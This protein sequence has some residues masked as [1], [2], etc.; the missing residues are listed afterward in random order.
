MAKKRTH[1]RPERRSIGGPDRNRRQRRD[2]SLHPYIL[3][4][5]LCLVIAVLAVFV[6]RGYII[7]GKVDIRPDFIG[8]A[9]PFDRFAQDFEKAYDETPLWYPHIFGGMPFQASGTYHHLQ[10]SFEA[11]INAVL[12][13]RLIGALHGR[14]FFHLLLGAVSMF[15]LSRALSLS[16]PASFIAATAFVFS[17]HM[18]ATEHAN[19]FICFMHVPLVFLAAYRVFDRGRLFDMLLLGAALGSQLSSFHPQIAFY[20]AMLIGLYAVYAVVNDLRDRT[21]QAA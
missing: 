4:G 11:L 19:R 21:P 2:R 18:M 10:Y 8:Q 9:I 5:L 14:F 17:T 7:E 1:T 6:Y 13:D 16:R 12:P 3:D 20:T 15:F